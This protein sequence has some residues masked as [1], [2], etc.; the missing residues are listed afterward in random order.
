MTTNKSQQ[1]KE[2]TFAGQDLNNSLFPK[3]GKMLLERK[4]VRGTPFEIIRDNTK[5]EE[6]CW[7]AMGLFKVVGNLN[8]KEAEKMIE[9]R[10]WELIAN[11]AACIAQTV[12]E[13]INEKAK[14]EGE[15]K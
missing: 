15:A 13:I 2:Q 12:Y 10:S 4:P 8:E 7:I 1:S 5:E 11:T 9:E 3:D 6:N 14:I